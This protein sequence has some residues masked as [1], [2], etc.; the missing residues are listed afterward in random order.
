[1]EGATRR[2]CAAAKIQAGD[3]HLLLLL[4]RRPG[5]DETI[6]TKNEQVWVEQREATTSQVCDEASQ[7]GLLPRQPCADAGE[8]QAVKEERLQVWEE[9]IP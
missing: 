4:C 1:M 8:V 6:Q 2:L 9:E 3:E 7:E 5:Q